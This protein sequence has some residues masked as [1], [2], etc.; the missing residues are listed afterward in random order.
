[1]NDST[2]TDKQFVTLRSPLLTDMTVYAIIYMYEQH[3]G[4]K[5]A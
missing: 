3:C 4:L 5:T 2:V 1:L